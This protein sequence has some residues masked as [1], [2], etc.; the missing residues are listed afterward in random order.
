MDGVKSEYVHSSED[1]MAATQ[2][3]PAAQ[4]WN[5]TSPTPARALLSRQGAEN[6]QLVCY[7]WSTRLWSNIVESYYNQLCYIQSA[8]YYMGATTSIL[9]ELI[10]IDSELPNGGAAGCG[11]F[12]VIFV[13]YLA[14]DLYLDPSVC[15]SYCVTSLDDC[16]GYGGYNNIYDSGEMMATLSFDPRSQ[17]ANDANRGIQYPTCCAFQ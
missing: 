13:N 4:G 12:V 10:G 6:D 14:F 11:V 16:A 1:V 17:C 15:Y 5:L 3:L 8:A 2:P 7:S 9:L